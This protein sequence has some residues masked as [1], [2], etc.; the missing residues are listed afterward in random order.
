MSD[1]DDQ[2]R[3]DIRFYQGEF[4]RRL[5]AA[6]RSDEENLFALMDE[7]ERRLEVL[8]PA[9]MRDT[10]AIAAMQALITR[11]DRE[12]YTLMLHLGGRGER[13]HIAAVAYDMAD[14]M[15]KARGNGGAA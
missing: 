4:R 15:L 6:L 10:A 14:V 1:N 12:G 5:R 2:A 3:S 11:A 8:P 13:E 7:V 9:G